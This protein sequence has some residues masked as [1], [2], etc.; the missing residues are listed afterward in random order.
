MS[1]RRIHVYWFQNPE[2][3][4][5]KKRNE[6]GYV[7]ELRVIKQRLK[8]ANHSGP[9]RWCYVRPNNPNEHVA[10]GLKE[11]MLW[12]RKIVSVAV[13]ICCFIVLKLAHSTTTKRTSTVPSPQAA[14]PSTPFTRA[15]HI[16][17][18]VFNLK[19][20]KS[21]LSISISRATLWATQAVIIYQLSA[22]VHMP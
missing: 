21:P 1:R 17:S 5:R 2:P 20:R 19:S 7:E 13:D 11:L 18:A 16:P 6:N 10:L 22:P 8:C 4:P 9:N 14:S 15:K 12:A 3:A